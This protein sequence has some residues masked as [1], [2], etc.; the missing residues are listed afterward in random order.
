MTMTNFLPVWCRIVDSSGINAMYGKLEDTN[1]V[2][3]W[4]T[5]GHS[6]AIFQNIPSFNSTS[7]FEWLFPRTGELISRF[8]EIF[9]ILL[10]S[11][12][13]FSKHVSA[14]RISFFFFFRPPQKIIS[15][16]RNIFSEI[17]VVS[18]RCAGRV[19]FFIPGSELKFHVGLPSESLRLDQLLPSNL[20]KTNFTLKLTI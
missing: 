14:T 6:P 18:I 3:V 1:K 5:L 8:W 4:E 12:L 7:N 19:N 10:T 2:R 9:G 11:H 20:L 13:L 16:P 15:Y 17:R